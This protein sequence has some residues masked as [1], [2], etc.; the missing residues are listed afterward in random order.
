MYII[1]KHVGEVGRDKREMMIINSRVERVSCDS[2]NFFF[3]TRL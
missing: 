2:F 1:I 3:V